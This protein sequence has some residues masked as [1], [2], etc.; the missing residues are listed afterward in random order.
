MEKRILVS[1]FLF[2]V[3]FSFCSNIFATNNEN[4]QRLIYDN[5]DYNANVGL[6]NNQ[7]ISVISVDNGSYIYVFT[8]NNSDLILSIGSRT[9]KFCSNMIPAGDENTEEIEVTSKYNV[10]RAS[11][12][13]STF[14]SV[15]SDVSRFNNT[16]FC[17]NTLSV[18]YSNCDIYINWAEVSYPDDTGFYLYD[19]IE[20]IIDPIIE[21]V[22]NVVDNSIIEDISHTTTD[23]YDLFVIFNRVVTAFFVFIIAFCLYNFL[24]KIIRK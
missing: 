1:L 23:F 16:E 20:P 12:G 15:F 14:D 8:S 5:Y 13:S 7:Y 11:K 24:R 19:Y 10:Y 17:N 6:D 9:I 4:I 21:P 18:V 2:I 22:N 3:L